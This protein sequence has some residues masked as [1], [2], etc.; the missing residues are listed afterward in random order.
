MNKKEKD[1]FVKIH[2]IGKFRLMV[3][4]YHAEIP[5]YIIARVIQINRNS[6]SMWIRRFY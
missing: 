6:I 2:G 3:M 5:I 4:L 1:K